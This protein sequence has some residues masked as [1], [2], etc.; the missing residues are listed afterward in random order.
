MNNKERIIKRLEDEHKEKE[1]ALVKHCEFLSMITHMTVE[2]EERELAN[3]QD[4]QAELSVLNEDI[5]WLKSVG[6]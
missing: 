5:E 2:Q 1:D 3:I 4:K 6:D